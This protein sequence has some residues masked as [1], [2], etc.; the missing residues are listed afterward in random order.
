MSHPS[1]PHHLWCYSSLLICCFVTLKPLWQPE[2]AEV[3]SSIFR[4]FFL[5]FFASS[6]SFFCPLYAPQCNSEHVLVQTVI[7]KRVKPAVCGFW[8]LFCV[9]NLSLWTTSCYLLHYM[10]S[11]LVQ[12]KSCVAF[13]QSEVRVFIKSP[14]WPYNQIMLWT[15]SCTYCNY[16]VIQPWQP[17]TFSF[18]PHKSPSNSAL[19]PRKVKLILNIRRPGENFTI[20]LSSDAKSLVCLFS[21]NYKM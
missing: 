9:T 6:F 21:N 1:I 3:T 7:F 12:N 18:T 19:E 10:H 8:P 11:T 17:P 13:E 16:T 14:G 15:P 20:H 5:F 2:T 4:F